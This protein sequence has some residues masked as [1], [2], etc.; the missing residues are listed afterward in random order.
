M[1][2]EEKVNSFATKLVGKEKKKI[3]KNFFGRSRCRGRA[4]VSFS[5]EKFKVYKYGGRYPRQ[6]LRDN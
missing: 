4:K 6:L 5:C 3:K 2:E 1:K